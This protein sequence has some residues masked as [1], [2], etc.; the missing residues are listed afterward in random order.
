MNKPFKPPKQQGNQHMD[1]LSE[2]LPAL[3]LPEVTESDHETGWS[4]WHEAVSFQESGF[5][6]AYQNT[7]PS[8]LTPLD[9]PK[10]TLAPN[11]PQS[12]T[13]VEDTPDQR[14]KREAMALLA[15]DHKRIHDAIELMW[16]RR[17][18]SAYILKLLSSGGDGMSRSRV[19]FKLEATAAL[20]ALSDLNDAASE[21]RMGGAR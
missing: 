5:P 6:E 17:E 15:R 8:A 3:P 20:L 14:K 11:Q 18:C 7:V 13:E 2:N 9:S 19:G 1:D 16:G 21:W 10:P 12:K 4:M